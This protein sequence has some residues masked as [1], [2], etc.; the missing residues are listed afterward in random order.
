MLIQAFQKSVICGCDCGMDNSTKRFEA[1]ITLNDKKLGEVRL[2][3][4]ERC[5]ELWV[6]NEY[7]VR[8]QDSFRLICFHRWNHQKD[9]INHCTLFVN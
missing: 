2:F 8:R 3:W 1:L 6:F 7:L 5:K 4:C 9:T